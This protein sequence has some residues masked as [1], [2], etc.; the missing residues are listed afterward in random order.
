MRF[1]GFPFVA[2]IPEPPF[3]VP[4]VTEAPVVILLLLLGDPY[5]VAVNGAI[6][7]RRG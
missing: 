1:A 4:A 6:R 3:S 2:T 7:G 5:L